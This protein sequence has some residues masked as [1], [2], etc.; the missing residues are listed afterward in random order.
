[1]EKPLLFLLL[2]L[3][4]SAAFAE[5]PAPT[6]AA[7]SAAEA[8]ATEQVIKP[9]SKAQA[10][11]SRFSRAAPVPVER[12]VRVLDTAAEKD[13]HGREFLRFAID[14][15]RAFDEHDEWQ[16]DSILGCAYPKERKVFV[17]RGDGYYPAK[18]VLGASARKA[19]GACT[20]APKSGA[21]LAEVSR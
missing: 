19:P 7:A 6:P 13:V 21:E 10:K 12:R 17:Q 2:T 1:M 14:V 20:S 18:S 4:A 16:K 15:R 3:C 5:P 8:L 9:L 11:R